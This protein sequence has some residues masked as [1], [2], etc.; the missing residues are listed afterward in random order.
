MSNDSDL[1]ASNKN[2]VSDKKKETMVHNGGS[3]RQLEKCFAGHKNVVQK[4]EAF[5]HS[6]S[7]QQGEINSAAHKN[8]VQNKETLLQNVRTQQ[9]EKT[10][11]ANKVTKKTAKGGTA[12]SKS[13]ES[14]RN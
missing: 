6:Y 12:N 4:Q 3:A 7:A 1:Q 13:A 11:A 5:D 2:S 14:G 8:V 10:F 9:G